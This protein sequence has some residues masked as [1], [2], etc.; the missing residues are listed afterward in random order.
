MAQKIKCVGVGLLLSK[1]VFSLGTSCLHRKWALNTSTSF[2]VALNFQTPCKEMD[3]NQGRFLPNG[4]S[5]Y[6]LKPE[7]QRDPASQFDPKSLQKGPWYKKKSLHIM[8]WYTST[9]AHTKHIQTHSYIQNTQGNTCI[10]TSPWLPNQSNAIGYLV[11]QSLQNL[12]ITGLMVFHECKQQT[13]W[14][15]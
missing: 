7:F 12:H 15:N 1:P 4:M 3:L 11:S 8:V 5:G 10:Q 13:F 6:V 9:P 2:A 14:F